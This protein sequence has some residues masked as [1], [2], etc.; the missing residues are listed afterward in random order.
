MAILGMDRTTAL[1][2][3]P[4]ATVVRCQMAYMERHGQ[5]V[6]WGNSRLDAL[7]DRLERGETTLE[8]VK[9]GK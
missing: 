1:W 2:G 5:E 7:L 8:E 3:T 9:A 6:D 4:A